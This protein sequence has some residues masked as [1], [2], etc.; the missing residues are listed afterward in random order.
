[1]PVLQRIDVAIDCVN[2]DAL[3]E[4]WCEALGYDTFGSVGQY[5][6]I[7]PPEGFTGPKLLFQQ[8]T[9]DVPPSKNR[10]HLDLIVGDAIE[11]EVERLCA[12]GAIRLSE[13][14][15]EAGTTW[16]T[17]ADPEGN[18]FCLCRL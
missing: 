1:M 13:P 2:A 16:T 6:S 15:T 7:V 14:I 4:F 18:E 17:M 9:D 8:V 5:L 11:T 10:L 3:A 12:L